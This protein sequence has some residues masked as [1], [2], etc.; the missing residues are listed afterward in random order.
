MALGLGPLF[1]IQSD[2]PT[3]VAV[4]EWSRA[5]SPSHWARVF[6]ISVQTMKRRFKDDKIRNKKLSDK[7]YQ[8]SLDD[9]PAS[10][11]LRIRQMPTIGPQD[12]LP[13]RVRAA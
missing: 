4:P 9:L 2:T 3:E 12:G 7:L 13:V 10:Y 11:R 6:G 1:S 5:D 8:I